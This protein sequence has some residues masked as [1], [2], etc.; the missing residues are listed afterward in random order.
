[1]PFSALSLKSGRKAV[2]PFHNEVEVSESNMNGAFRLRSVELSLNNTV[3]ASCGVITM[4][5]KTRTIALAILAISAT[6]VVSA[7]ANA[8]HPGHGQS[9]R[10]TVHVNKTIVN[11]RHGRQWRDPRSA[12]E[13][14]VKPTAEYRTK[15]GE[16]CREISTWVWIGGYEEKLHG[17]A[18]RMPDGSWRRVR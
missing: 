2:C 10:T 7:P 6:A 5:K 11:E 17:T 18:C 8:D 16:Y 12:A 3:S 15:S 4:W 9:Y 13:P 1:M 14:S